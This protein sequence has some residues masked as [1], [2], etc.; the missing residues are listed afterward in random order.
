MLSQ[1]EMAASPPDAQG[2]VGVVRHLSLFVMLLQDVRMLSILGF[3]INFM[4][5]G[6]WLRINGIRGWFRVLSM[7]H[8]YLASGACRFLSA[9]WGCD[10]ASTT[11][12]WNWAILI[13]VRSRSGGRSIWAGCWSTV[14]CNWPAPQIP[15]CSQV[16]YLTCPVPSQSKCCECLSVGTLA[17]EDETSSLTDDVCQSFG[18]KPRLDALIVAIARQLL[19]WQGRIVAVETKTAAGQKIADIYRRLG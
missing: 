14:K 11:R 13:V 10:P 2:W 5:L 16:L 12:A 1:V 19:C 6:K 3:Q 7:T 9:T 8:L 4:Q 15:G 17:R 18:D